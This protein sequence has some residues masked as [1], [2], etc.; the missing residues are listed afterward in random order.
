MNEMS[1]QPNNQDFDAQFEQERREFLNS[2]FSF[3]RALSIHDIHNDAVSRPKEN[4]MRALQKLR[5]YSQAQKGVELKFQ[6]HVISI[7]GFR[8]QNHFSTVEASKVVPELMD[9][10]MLEVINFLPSASEN[11]IGGFFSKWALHCGVHQKPKELAG[12]FSGLKISYIDPSRIDSR[13]KSKQLLMSP[14]YALDH[15]Y[16]LRNATIQ[17]FEGVSSNQVISQKK[18]RRALLEL[19][20]VGRVNPYQ[21]VALSLLRQHDYEVPRPSELE[22]NVSEAIATA[23]LT[24]VIA[25][26]LEYSIREQINLGMV[27]LVY[28]I[29]LLSKEV[30][31]LTRSN[32]RLSQ[33]EY[34]R[35]L[36]A[37][38]AGVFRL[39][40][41]QGSS[42]PALERLLALFEA[43]QGNVKTS[44]SLNLDSRLLRMVS[45][46]VALTSD[47]PYRDAYNP[48]EAMKIIGSRATHSAQGNLDT[49][50]YFVFVRFLGVYPVG[51]L[52]ELSDQNRAVIFRPDGQTKAQPLVKL[53]PDNLEASG[54]V[55]DLGAEKNLSIIK[56]LDAKREAIKTSAFF[57]E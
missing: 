45:Q 4:F 56:A 25:K 22:E 38:S 15:Y 9:V 43:T 26:E 27:G 21:L 50:L 33:I 41:A 18:I 36:E 29:G 48:Q 28:N 2:T 53:L 24:M 47:R 35:V 34:K 11:D 6:D 19:A 8:V 57:F 55:I 23:L 49:L 13:L 52:V 30:A 17:F 3:L 12:E 1:N 10:A 5:Q 40:K 20:E 54:P 39:I 42:R 31:G 51:S 37:Q 7:V 32:K 44:V 46:Y 16:M 14:R